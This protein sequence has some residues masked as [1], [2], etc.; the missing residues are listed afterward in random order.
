MSI[1]ICRSAR[2]ATSTNSRPYLFLGQTSSDDDRRHQP[3]EQPLARSSDG[4]PVDD[5]G[6]VDFTDLLALAAA[7]EREHLIWSDGDFVPRF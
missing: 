7:F 5:D 1:V 3:S 4:P 2:L 6:D